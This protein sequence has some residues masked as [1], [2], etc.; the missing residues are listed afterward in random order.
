MNT[1]TLSQVRKS[2]IT[3]PVTRVRL[4]HVDAFTDTPLS[5]N[6][7]GVVMNATGLTDTQMQLIAREVAASET[8]FI[9]PPTM[10]S[11]D[12]RIRWFSPRSEIPLCGHATVAAFHALAEEGMAGM[13]NPGSYKFTMETQSGNLPVTVEKNARGT[14]VYLGLPVPVFARV[15]ECKLD[16]GRILDMSLDEF[17]N[18]MP[19]VSSQYLYV[20]LRKLSTLLSLKPNFFSMTQFLKSRNFMGLCVFTLETIED[21]SSV[22]SRFFAPTVGIDEDPVTGS[23]NGPL[24][25]Y[26]FQQGYLSSAGDTIAITGEQGDAINRKGRVTIELSVENKEVKAVRIGGRAVTLMT[27]DMVVG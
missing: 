10:P 17:E 27:G 4:K 18:R 14:Q 19:I 22:H 21:S 24:G 1:E 5:G 26:L 13:K 20:P 25:V 2:G 11:A 9:L 23:A 15:G 6:A 8:S 7:A 16:L 3:E 12:L